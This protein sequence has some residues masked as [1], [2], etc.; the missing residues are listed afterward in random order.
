MVAYCNFWSLVFCSEQN[1]YQ[2]IEKIVKEH[3]YRT[4]SE[5]VR[6]KDNFLYKIMV[7]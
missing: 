2:I 7:I 6:T 3:Y 1:G 4:S 5:L